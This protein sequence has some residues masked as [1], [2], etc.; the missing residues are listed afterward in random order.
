MD[1]DRVVGSIMAAALGDAL[2]A[3]YEG[4]FLERGLWRLIGTDRGKHRWTDDTQMSIDV[5]ESLLTHRRVNQDDLAQRFSQSYHWTRGYGPGAA[6]ILK[7]IRAGQPWQQASVSVYREGS[8]GNGGAMR[9]PALG[10][11]YAQAPESELVAAARA[12]AQVTHAHPFAC[13]AAA[14]IAL[15][16]A[17][18]S[19]NQSTT[20]IMERLLLHASSA[21]FNRRLNIANQWLRLPE[22]I[23]PKRAASELG[24]GIA[25]LDSCVT[26][27]FVAL[28]LREHD[29]DTLL[30]YTIKLGGDVDTIASMACAIW[31][32]ANGFNKI[33]SAHVQRLE[34]A[35]RLQ[36]LAT[37]FAQI[38]PHS[39]IS[40]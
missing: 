23:L 31:G 14:L 28:K 5:I 17:L 30:A 11:F 1:A 7:R 25:A 29:F 8:F 9:A 16:T 3:P 32:A 39:Q 36:S 33:P 22:T 34:Q 18:A 26:A 13:A 4:G 27:I 6:K 37:S 10:L 38:L 20:A 40:E 35:Q 21:E 12:C 19:K 2:G 15:C 24:H